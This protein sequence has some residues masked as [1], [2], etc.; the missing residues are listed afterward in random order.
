MEDGK[1]RVRND[2]DNITPL[3]FNHTPDIGV[4]E[5]NRVTLLK[6]QTDD[7]WDRNQT[8]RNGHH[9]QVVQNMLDNSGTTHL[10][11]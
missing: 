3:F 2:F 7:T 1:A 6:S 4:P 9:S 11:N 5:N 10:T 8:I